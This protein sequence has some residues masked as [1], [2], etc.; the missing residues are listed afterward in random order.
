MKKIYKTK[1]KKYNNFFDKNLTKL[2][3]II[4]NY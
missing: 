1:K 4:F 2:V 3:N